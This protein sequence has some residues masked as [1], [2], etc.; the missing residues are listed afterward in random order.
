MNGTVI[1]HI[2]GENMYTKRYFKGF[3]SYDLPLPKNF[4][5]PAIFILNTDK[6]SGPGEHWCVA[7]F[8][9][10][11]ICEFFDS[12]GKAPCFYNFD[13]VLYEH[14]KHVV[15]NPFRV[16]GFN[17]TCGHH[18]LFFVLFRYYGYNASTIFKELLLHKKL[19]DLGDNDQMVFNYIKDFFGHSFADFTY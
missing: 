16:Q 14:A 10:D 19:S 1:E 5:K 9:S 6:W 7:N 17:P 8:I 18:C 11:D 2:L 13:K 3:G 4:I 12:Y 15:Y